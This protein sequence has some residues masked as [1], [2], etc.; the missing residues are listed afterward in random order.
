MYTS[1]LT[2][3]PAL[4]NTGSLMPPQQNLR[5]EL[6]LAN[7]LDILCCWLIFRLIITLLLPLIAVTRKIG[8][9][10]HHT[11]VDRFC[12]EQV[13]LQELQPS[14]DNGLLTCC[15]LRCGFLGFAVNSHLCQILFDSVVMNLDLQPLIHDTILRCDLLFVS[16]RQHEL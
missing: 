10:I 13:L 15:G 2:A 3:R 12:R 14:F 1:L 6:S 4:K 9:V 7:K 8:L 5:W 16:S 11:F